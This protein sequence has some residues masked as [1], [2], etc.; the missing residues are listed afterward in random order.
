MFSILSLAVVLYQKRLELN[1][2]YNNEAKMGDGTL[3]VV[4]TVPPVKTSNQLA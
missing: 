4:K 3:V 2:S 1:E